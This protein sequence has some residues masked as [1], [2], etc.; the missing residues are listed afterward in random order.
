MLSRELRLLFTSP[1][2]WLL[3][4]AVGVLAFIAPAY[5]PTL[6]LCVGVPFVVVVAGSAADHAT[7]RALLQLGRGPLA[8]TLTRFVA[9]CLGA[10]VV[11]TPIVA[12]AWLRAP[13]DPGALATFAIG[14]GCVGV[15]VVGVALACASVTTSRAAAALATLAVTCGAW[16]LDVARAPLSFATPTAALRVFE[17]GLIDG[18]DVVTLLAGGLG[19]TLF[20][21]AWLPRTAPVEARALRAAA[22]VVVTLLA[23][24]GASQLRASV[25]ITRAQRASFP[26]PWVRALA[27][28]GDRVEVT[29]HARRDDPR[30][31]ALERH[32]LLPMRR[33][34]K[35][36]VR[37]AEDAT[38]R[39]ATWRVGPRE[40]VRDDVTPE[41]A[42]RT[43]VDLAGVPLA[44]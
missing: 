6:A 44:P 10:S 13:G 29:V 37:F 25:D 33:Y 26:A 1:L 3:T 9:S 34:A 4:L 21:A 22:I 35:V 40:A 20:A 36:R 23:C 7:A 39:L 2:L 14:A 5:A 31:A 30:T 28:I 12:A 27:Q 32:V 17:Q 38:A 43:V 11:L 18:K 8:L 19:M 24:G 16:A 15:A 41:A 42:V